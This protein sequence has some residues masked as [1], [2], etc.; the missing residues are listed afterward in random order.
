MPSDFGV[1]RSPIRQKTS[2]IRNCHASNGLEFWAPPFVSRQKRGKRLCNRSKRPPN[3]ERIIKIVTEENKEELRLSGTLKNY[4][5][6]DSKTTGFIYIATSI[7]SKA[8]HLLYT[9]SRYCYKTQCFICEG[10]CNR[11]KE[12]CNICNTFGIIY[13]ALSIRCAPTC[14]TCKAIHIIYIAIRIIYTS[15][16]NICKALCNTCR[17][18][19]FIAKAYAVMTK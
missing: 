5:A 8:S 2:R 10:L 14:N 7:H 19:C 17:S 9:S 18:S 16:C 12:A 1:V 15:A 11:Y 6:R 3:E 13:E 4:S